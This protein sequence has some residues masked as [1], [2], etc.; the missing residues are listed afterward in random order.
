[1]DSG[2]SSD[3]NQTLFDV[4]GSGSDDV[5]VSGF[6]GHIL[7]YDGIS[8]SGMTSGVTNHLNGIWGSSSDDPLMRISLIFC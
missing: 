7:H 6:Q 3:P 8:W 2:I 5:F 4:W 1:M